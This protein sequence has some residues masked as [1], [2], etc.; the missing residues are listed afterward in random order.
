MTPDFQQ[1]I[2]QHTDLTEAAQKHAGK[3]IAGAMDEKYNAFLREIIRLS[4]AKEID[5]TK[6]ETLLKH[7]VYDTLPDE[8][9]SKTDLA[10]VNI[11]HQLRLVEEFYRSTKTPNESPH[12][13]TMIEQLWLMKQRI[14]DHYDVFK[15]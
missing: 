11:A 1:A 4:D 15:I 14:E 8:W 13:Q 12:L 7:E 6:P 9:K 3:A 10:L 2:A 5:T